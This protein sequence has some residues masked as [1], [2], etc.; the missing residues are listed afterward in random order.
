MGKEEQGESN[1]E[2]PVV[3]SRKL[4]DQRTGK[5]H[6]AEQKRGGHQSEFSET[7]EGLAAVHKGIT[8][9]EPQSNDVPALKKNN[10]KMQTTQGSPP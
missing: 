2:K 6:A 4:V 3:E 5:K 1:T 7:R 10:D 8:K 9:Q